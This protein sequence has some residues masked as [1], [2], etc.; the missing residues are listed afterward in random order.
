MKLTNKKQGSYHRVLES[1]E[2]DYLLSK[3]TEY[4]SLTQMAKALG[5]NRPTLVFKTKKLGIHNQMPNVRNQ[6]ES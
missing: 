6:K 5:I 2:R 1:L 3:S 4:Q